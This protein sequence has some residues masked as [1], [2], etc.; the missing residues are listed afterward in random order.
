MRETFQSTIDLTNLLHLLP[1]SFIR[2]SGVIQHMQ[3]NNS[4]SNNII[5]P[6][7]CYLSTITSI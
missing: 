6:V 3:P 1:A 2:M 7:N 4:N 5:I